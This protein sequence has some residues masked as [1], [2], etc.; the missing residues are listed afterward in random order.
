MKRY[1]AP[2][3]AIYT[4]F[5]L[6]MMFYGSGRQ[7]G[8]RGYMQL[9]PF[10]TIEKFFQSRVEAQHFIVNIVGNILVFIPFGWLGLASRK[11]FS[12]PKLLIGF[13]IAIV[14]IESLQ[15]ITKRGTADI[16]DVFLNTIGMLLGYV[17]YS[18][19]RY[20]YKDAWVSDEGL[21]YEYV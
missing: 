12:F 13:P 6:Y 9:H 7:V 11:Y 3:L 8:P 15:Y 2:L 18:I 19:V 21:E 10:L 5:L 1:Y 20:F 16:D 14:V 4:L 17:T